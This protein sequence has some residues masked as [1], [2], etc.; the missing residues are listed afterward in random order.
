[1]TDRKKYP[2]ATKARWKSGR[3]TVATSGAT[4]L[5]GKQWGAWN[6]ALVVAMLKGQGILVFSVDARSHLKKVATIV[7]DHGRIRSVHPGPDGALYFTT[8]NGSTDGIYRV[9]P[10]G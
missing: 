8:S 9:V 10:A 6:G 7:T 1:M 4:F 2:K 5:T 3:P